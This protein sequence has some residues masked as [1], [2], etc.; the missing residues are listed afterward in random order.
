MDPISI[1]TWAFRAVQTLA[2]PQLNQAMCVIGST[3]YDVADETPP[4]VENEDGNI[5]ILLKEGLDARP[6]FATIAAQIQARELTLR[7]DRRALWPSISLN[8]GLTDAGTR[9][10]SLAWNWNGSV[11]VA[12]P[13]F[14][15]GLKQAQIREAYWNLAELQ[16]QSD[17][18]SQQVRFEVVQTQLAVRA[19]KA[20]LD[21]AGE[22]L[23]NAQERLRLAEGRY[24]AGVGNIIELG[25]A[26]VALTSA[27]QQKVQAEYQVASARAQLLKALGRT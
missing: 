12:V 27:S 2:S 14:E 5:D 3:P 7:A 19:A 6:E 18:L 22:A 10:G 24:E 1:N 17:A 23:I 11:S 15:G 8:T 13:F 21:A 26:Q 25:D 9:F 16:A 20:A 4:P